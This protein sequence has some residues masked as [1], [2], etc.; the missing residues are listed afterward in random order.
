MQLCTYTNACR[1]IFNSMK[2]SWHS[3]LE[4]YTSHFIERVVCERWVGDWTKTAKYSRSSCF[5]FSST[6]FS[7][8]WAVQQG[9]WGPASGS[10]SIIFSPT[11]LNFLSPVLYNNLTS[12][13]FLRASHLLSVQ[14]VECQGYPLIS[15]TGC[16]CYLH[17]C[18]SYFDSSARGQCV[19]LSMAQIEMFD[20]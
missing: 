9:D 4:K 19:T 16:S 10:H 7:F 13:Y 3:S 18:I 8:S 1:N 14:P 5:I 20:I 15:S 6:S 11:D 2:R 17:R 12:T